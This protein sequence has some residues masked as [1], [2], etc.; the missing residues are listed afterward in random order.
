MFNGG[1]DDGLEE[2]FVLEI[3]DAIIERDV[4]GVV[5][6]WVIWVNGTGGVEGP[7]AREEDLFVVFV[8][9]DTHD[10]VGRPEG[11]LDAVAVV[12][13]DVDVQDARVVAEEL[14]DGEDDVVD[15]A[16]TRGFAFL[17]VVEAAGPVDGDVRLA[18]AELAGGVHGCAGVEGAVVE[19]TVEDGTVVAYTIHGGGVAR[20]LGEFRVH[21]EDVGRGGDAEEVN[22]VFLVELLYFIF[23][24]C[25]RDVGVHSCVHTIGKDQAFR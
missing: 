9:G 11:L 16:E 5:A 24:C 3:V 19:E 1:A 17:G 21:L 22:V 4:D 8:E 14:E 2:L 7:S 13:V 23:G 12:D 18:V 10:A 20:S 25:A 15:V 6:S